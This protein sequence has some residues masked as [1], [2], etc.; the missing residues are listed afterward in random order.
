MEDTFSGEFSPLEGL[1]VLDLSDVKGDI[2]SDSKQ[3]KKSENK[4][5]E[6]YNQE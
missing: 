3:I 6:A 5:K 1:R 2:N 4:L